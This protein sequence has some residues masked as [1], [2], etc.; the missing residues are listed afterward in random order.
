MEIPRR[1]YYQKEITF[2]VS[3]SYGPGRYDA[4][5]EEKGQDYPLSY[6]RWTEGRNLQSVVE[7]IAEGRLNVQALIS[8]R[9]PIERAVEAYDLIRAATS[10]PFL[11]VVLTYPDEDAPLTDVRRRLVLR[12]GRRPPDEGVRLG[13]L[14]AGN[15]ATNVLY[16]LLRRIHGVELVGVASASGANAA[17]AGRRFGFRYTVTDDSQLLEDD[18]INTIA[19]LTRHHL[20]ARQVLA[21]LEAGKH[22]FC[23]KPLALNREE[24]AEISHA[25]AES[26]RL[27]CVGFNRRFAPLAR[28]MKDFL[29]EGR[30]PLALVYRVN[31]GMLPSDHWLHDPAQGGGRIVGEACH[32]IDFLTFLSGSLPVRVF[33]QSLPGDKRY[34]ADNVLLR[35]EFKDG[36][37]GCIA[38][39]ANGDR[40]Y[41]KERVEVFGGGRT[42]VLDDFRRLELA[43]GGRRTSRRAWL[44][45]EKG[46]REIWQAFSTSVQSGGPAPIPYVELAAVTLTSFAAVE[47][48]SAG[49]PVL[50]ETPAIG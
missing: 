36:S 12:E 49:K 50:V 6:V 35:V 2:R 9:F 31:A 14:G 45:Q 47:S 19:V 48:L 42:A 41:P 25:L 37:L 44:R 17:R 18:T 33:T 15:F 43:Q 1:T 4:S 32:F 29:A 16:P 46:H 11:G 20:H 38:Y 21:A 3:R 8:H 27:L 22:V 23:E 30:D 7:L 10:E 28:H 26:D 5:Y 24:L 34:P 13:A 40:S 39:L